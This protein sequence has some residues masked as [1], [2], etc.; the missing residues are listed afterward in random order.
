ME[1]IFRTLDWET[2]GINVNGKYLNHLRF[3]D[4][5]V[6][7]TSDP[8]ELKVMVENLSISSE[9]V[10]LKMNMSKT[11][12]MFNKFA[13]PNPIKIRNTTLE[14]VEEYIYLGQVIS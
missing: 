14:K 9:R 4:D 12:V 1:E 11:K 13:N 6:L 2:T 5:I 3:A 7:F 8:Q 10:G